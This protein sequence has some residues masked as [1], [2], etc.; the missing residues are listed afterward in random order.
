MFAE[1][2]FA[3]EYPVVKVLKIL[4]CREKL[5]LIRILKNDLIILTPKIDLILPITIP[6]QDIQSVG[7]E[8]TDRAQRN[9]PYKEN[10]LIACPVGR[11]FL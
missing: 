2:N 7:H 10:C 1:E 6:S 3:F 5:P 9:I 8:F 4:S 11:F